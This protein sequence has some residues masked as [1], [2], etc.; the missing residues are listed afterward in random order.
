MK[1]ILSTLGQAF[2]KSILAVCMMSLISL[3]GIMILPGQPAF[4]IV[5]ISSNQTKTEYTI[6]GFSTE[7]SEVTNRDQAYEEAVK[8]TERPLVGI[9]KI[10]EHD[11]QSYQEENPPEGI[12]EKAEEAIDQLTGK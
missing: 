7:D 2:R 12:L 3:A 6:D 11:L 8:A 9:E 10:Y 4:A 5:D 1:G